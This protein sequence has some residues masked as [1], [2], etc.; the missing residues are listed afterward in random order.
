MG[1]S[2]T[3][4]EALKMAIEGLLELLSFVNEELE[5]A[6]RC[7]TNEAV[8][9]KA[10]LNI[11]QEKI[12]ACKEALDLSEKQYTFPDKLDI[13]NCDIKQPAQDYVLICKRC[14]DDL[15]LEY[16]PD[17][18]P[19]QEPVSWL[20]E[21]QG[22]TEQEYHQEPVAYL[23]EVGGYGII[24]F[25]HFDEDGAYP[26]YTHPAAQPA[27]DGIELEWYNKGWNDALK[28]KNT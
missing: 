27:Q 16:V 22:I 5:I 19:A 26:V 21:M 24:D 15:G 9:L 28:E 13:A 20:D 12:N 14:G 10:K 6:Y 18:Q 7:D 4:D 25:A 8:K 2:M 1:G 17:E 3:K 11:V 23:K